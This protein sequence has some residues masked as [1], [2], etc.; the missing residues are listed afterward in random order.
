[1]IVLP[2]FEFTYALLAQTSNK[3]IMIFENNLNPLIHINNSKLL[4]NQ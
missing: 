1:M 2:I 3:E 4:N